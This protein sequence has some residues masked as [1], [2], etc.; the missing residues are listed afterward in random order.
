MLE[1]IITIQTV[2]GIKIRNT[3]MRIP[4]GHILKLKFRKIQTVGFVQKSIITR[5]RRINKG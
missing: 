1:A 3:Y 4:T 2:E 5:G